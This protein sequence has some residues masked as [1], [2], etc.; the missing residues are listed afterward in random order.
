VGVTKLQSKFNHIYAE[1]CRTERPRGL[2]S[3]VCGRSLIGIVS[4]NPAEGMYVCLVWV[5]C[6]IKYRTLRQADHSSRGVV[7]SVVC[8]SVIVKPRWWGGHGTS[9]CF[10]V[11]KKWINLSVSKGTPRTVLLVRSNIRE[12]NGRWMNTVH[13]SNDEWQGTTKI[14][15]D[16]PTPQPH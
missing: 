13:S 9:G 11:E 1:F 6:V 8:L 12:Q 4:S 10:T 14:L 15:D 7:R 3:W 16:K 2:R 5:L